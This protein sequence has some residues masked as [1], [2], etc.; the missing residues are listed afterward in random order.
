MQFTCCACYILVLYNVKSGFP[1]VYPNGLCGLFIDSTACSHWFSP[2]INLQDYN[3]IVCD[4][5]LRY[6]FVYLNC[7]W[8]YPCKILALF[9][10]GHC[11]ENPIFRSG[12]CHNT[13]I[14]FILF[15]TEKSLWSSRSQHHGKVIWLLFLFIQ[16]NT[17]IRCRSPRLGQSCHNIHLIKL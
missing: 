8:Q 2:H 15:Y 11:A 4:F 1:Q 12:S 3:R 13:L 5:W 6:L 17:N 9:A 7:K 10:M 16:R 14:V